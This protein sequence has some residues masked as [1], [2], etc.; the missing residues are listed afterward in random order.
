MKHY[1][2][3]PKVSLCFV[4]VGVLSACEVIFEIPVAINKAKSIL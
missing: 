3:L 1:L 4:A 2:L